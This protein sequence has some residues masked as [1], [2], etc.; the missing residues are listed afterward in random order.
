MHVNKELE[1]ENDINCVD[2]G[3]ESV[4]HVANSQQNFDDNEEVDNSTEQVEYDGT[5]TKVPREGLRTILKIVLQNIRGLKDRL[6][7]VHKPTKA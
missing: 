1:V 7:I 5:I 4:G 2:S 3:N 6:N